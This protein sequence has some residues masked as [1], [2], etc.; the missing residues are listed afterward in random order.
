MD[1]AL[2]NAVAESVSLEWDSTAHQQVH[3]S[4]EEMEHVLR[5]WESLDG[6]KWDEDTRSAVSA[7]VETSTL[8]FEEWKTYLTKVPDGVNERYR[9][10]MS[11][12]LEKRLIDQ[13]AFD[14]EIQA[15]DTFSPAMLTR[16]GKAFA[17]WYRAA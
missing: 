8:S 16:R 13:D 7:F 10:V 4:L 12:L 5:Y 1:E 9:K 2:S 3:L 14:A 11:L 6:V 17:D 15:M